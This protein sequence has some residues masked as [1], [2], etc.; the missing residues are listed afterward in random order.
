MAGVI[1]W[2]VAA[3][4]VVVIVVAPIVFFRYV[5]DTQKRLRIVDP[6]RVYRSG[7]MTVDGFAD[8]VERLHLRTIIN[9]Q[10]EFPDPDIHLSFWSKRT[11]K[12]SEL[13]RQ[14]GVRYVH[15]MPTLLPRHLISEHRPPAIDQFLSVLDDPANYPVLIHCH[16]GL[17]RT[18][19]LTAIYRMEYQGW[20][21]DQAFLDMKAQGF[22]PWVCV[23]ANDY[24]KQYV[25]TYRVGVR[26]QQS[27]ERSMDKKP[28]IG[29]P[30]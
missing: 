1:R 11:I 22:G 3:A 19:I 8:A 10:D 6:G 9:V 12:E 2:S 21:Q 24:V 27:R 29:D 30:G 4:L 20:T 16:A 18:G 15:L 5:Y 14:L 25:L 13:C 23:S 26:G 17:H 28:V 7:Q